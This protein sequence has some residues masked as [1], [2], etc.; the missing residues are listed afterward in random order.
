[1]T[2]RPDTPRL[3]DRAEAARLARLEREAEALRANLRR[4]KQQSRARTTPPE[5]A[6]QD[7]SGNE[8]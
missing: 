7:T 5:A 3:T 4:R 2:D 1:M 6:P 8:A